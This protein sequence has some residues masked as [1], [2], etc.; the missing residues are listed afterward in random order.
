MLHYVNPKR[1]KRLVGAQIL[2]RVITGTVAV[3]ASLG[4]GHAIA[5]T[6]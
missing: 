2:T 5:E 6:I 3:G 4:L 1:S